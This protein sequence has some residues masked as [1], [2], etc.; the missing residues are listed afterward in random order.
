LSTQQ[1]KLRFRQDTPTV[2]LRDLTGHEERG[3]ADVT[4]QSVVN[5]LSRLVQWPADAQA[6]T[7]EL[8]APDRDRLLATIYERTFGKRIESTAVCTACA[9]P[10][11]LGFSLDDLRAALDHSADSSTT[12]AL[13]DGTFRTAGGMRFRL[14]TAQEEIDAGLLPPEEGRRTLASRCILEGQPDSLDELESAIEEVAPV[15]DL[16]IATACPECGAGQF[17][18]FDVQFY[19]LRAIRQERAQLSQEIHRIASAYGWGLDEILGLERSER[20]ALAELIESDL[21]TR[22]RA[23]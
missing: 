18:R 14:P 13:P 4:T 7:S 2:V 3:V 1:V 9:S 17:V 15:L 23:L 8:A 22:R 5:L 6:T 11:D 16:D 19:L 10:F 20:R 21:P 12:R